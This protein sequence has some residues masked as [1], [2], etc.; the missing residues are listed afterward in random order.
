MVTDR[1]ALRPTASVTEAVMVCVPVE[2]LLSAKL[3]PVPSEPSR[4]EVQWI[5]APRSPS[6]ASVA[7]AVEVIAAPGAKTE[8]AAGAVSVRGGAASTRVGI[9]GRP[10]LPAPSV[11]DAVIRWGA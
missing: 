10:G 1:L 8:P 7:V 2:R 11:A 5:A 9:E 3:A 4:L 6:S